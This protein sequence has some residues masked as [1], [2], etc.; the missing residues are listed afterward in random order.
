MNSTGKDSIEFPCYENMS[1]EVE[2]GEVFYE[3]M[4]VLVLRQ[5]YIPNFSD[6]KKT[7]VHDQKKPSHMK[8]NSG[9]YDEL[10]YD[11]DDNV[12]DDS[13]QTKTQKFQES[14]KNGQRNKQTKSNVLSALS[15]FIIGGVLIGL[16][17]T[18]Y[19]EY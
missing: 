14:E 19:G 12:E 18:L 13:V 9:I 11:I 5:N 3:N 17:I 10:E 1:V 16:I 8:R 4:D 15:G 2:S 7:S 6:E